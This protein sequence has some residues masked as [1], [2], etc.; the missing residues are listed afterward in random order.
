M[1]LCLLVALRLVPF[2]SDI[3]YMRDPMALKRVRDDIGAVRDQMQVFTEAMA[4]KGTTQGDAAVIAV[5]LNAALSESDR[6]NDSGELRVGVIINH[7]VILLGFAL[8]PATR[9]ELGPLQFAL[10]T[11]V[12]TRLEVTNRHFATTFLRFAPLQE[13]ELEPDLDAHT[14][15]SEIRDGMQALKETSSH[16][17][18]PLAREHWVVST[19][20]LTISTAICVPST[21][22]RMRGFAKAI[23]AIS[24]SNS[25]NC[26][27]LSR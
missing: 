15:L 13:L 10:S 4:A 24:T 1:L 20:W 18:T 12:Q 8:N 27:S 14:L 2:A 23:N 5:Y 26:R 25:R 11:H 16:E 21:W 3:A 19:A 7:G 9:D 22:Q 6:A 17:L